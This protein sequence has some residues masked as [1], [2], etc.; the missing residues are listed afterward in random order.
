MNSLKLKLKRNKENK[1]FNEEK[2]NKNENNQINSLLFKL[3]NQHH[4]L[5]NLSRIIINSFDNNNAK[6]TLIQNQKSLTDRNNYNFNFN[7]NNKEL[8][9]SINIA[10]TFL[11]MKNKINENSKNDNNDNIN[12]NYLNQS[13]QKSIY[14]NKED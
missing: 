4:K 1:Q 10:N 13:L 14:L 5:D 3:K 9:N 12:N 7:L 6:P 8:L 2:N 11:E